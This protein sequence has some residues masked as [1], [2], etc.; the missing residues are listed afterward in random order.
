VDR[1]FVTFSGVVLLAWLGSMAWLA[2]TRD[3]DASGVLLWGAT[4]IVAAISAIPVPLVT[5]P[6]AAGPRYYFLPFV[7][8]AW[9]L[10][11]VAGRWLGDV[12]R[13][14]T[15]A[16]ILL[17]SASLGLAT[18]FSRQ[19][20]TTVADLSWQRE[21]ERCAEVTTEEA[22]VPIYYDGSTTYW[23]LTMTPGTCSRVLE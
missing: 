4:L 8:L 13:Y 9:T 5:D 10:I 19:P 18:T 16:V 1:G 11:W 12:R 3:K 7:L 17:V 6:V 22:G 15:V 23:S 2:L 21:L 20:S 14:G